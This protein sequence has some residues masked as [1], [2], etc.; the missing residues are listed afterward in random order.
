MTV[1]SLARMA[2]ALQKVGLRSG[3]V[4][5]EAAIHQ[6]EPFRLG[7]A[8][9]SFLLLVLL[10]TVVA[11]LYLLLVRTPEFVS[12]AKFVVRTGSEDTLRRFSLDMLVAPSLLS[13]M[14]ST[15]Q[16]THI[17]LAY[18][19]SR[20]AIEDVGG[21]ELLQK[22]YG[23]DDID[24]LSRLHPGDSV[25]EIS[26]Y[27]RTKVEAVLDVPSGIITL[28]VRA[29]RREDAFL[30]AERLLALS[31]KLINEISE[32]S[33]KDS[34]EQAQSE[35]LKARTLVDEKRAALAAFRA[36]N[37]VLDPSINAVALGSMIANLTKERLA[38]EA[39]LSTL[40]N[41]M[42]E[43][44]R[45]VRTVRTQ[46]ATL[47]DQIRTLERQLTNPDEQQ[48]AVATKMSGYEQAQLELKFAEKL[49]EISETAYHKAFA[50]L[51]RQQ[52]YLVTL[53]KPTQPGRST[54]PRPFL[55]GM[56]TFI[57]LSALWS[58]LVLTVA[59]IVEHR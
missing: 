41:S 1:Q 8:A 56:L 49:S 29:Y 2:T 37:E 36:Q 45:T 42:G 46:L 3:E 13:G 53:V 5:L 47:Q 22:I 18:L 28:Q 23:G 4:S 52:L 6:R 11:V 51:Q 17:V 12:E 30:L 48:R 50:D 7:A 27:W 21:K 39:Q 16:D 32:R 33:R 26:K 31:E 43:D 34:L 55:D 25:E 14:K 44:S 57:W 9:R 19:K 35:L 15:S 24:Y 38:L 20:S 54:Y 10:P 58:V 40:K 59:G